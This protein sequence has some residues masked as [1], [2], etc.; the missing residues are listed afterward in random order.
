VDIAQGDESV[1]AVTA[2]DAAVEI[3]DERTVGD[4]ILESYRA[5]FRQ[6][7]AEGDSLLSRLEGGGIELS[8]RT[9]RVYQ[10][11]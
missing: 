8:H 1:A 2:P 4:E 7:D 3:E 10:N 6:I 5:V 11:V 9:G